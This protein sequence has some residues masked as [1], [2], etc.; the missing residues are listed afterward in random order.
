M[1]D[2]LTV[3]TQVFLMKLYMGPIPISPISDNLTILTL[4]LLMKL[5]IRSVPT[6]PISD[7]LAILTFNNTD[8]STSDY[9]IE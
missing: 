2:H 1:F 6:S 8:L 9:T 7:P 4:V 5:F 3:F